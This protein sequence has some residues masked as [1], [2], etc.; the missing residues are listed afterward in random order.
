MKR[1][2][3]A[4]T[5]TPQPNGLT[6]LTRDGTTSHAKTVR[7]R[8]P[9]IVLVVACSQRKR[10]GPPH[11]LRLSSI[12][13]SSARR[14]KQWETRL[15]RVKATCHAAKDLYMGDHWQAACQ[16][17]ELTQR[18][19]S[20]TE[21]WVISAGYGLIS[22]GTAIKPYSAT[23]ASG[24]ADSVWRGAQDGDRD[25]YL[26]EWWHAV[27]RER[28]LVDLLP[29]RGDGAVVVAAG[30]AYL[31]AVSVDLETM[32]AHDS[33]E[34]VSVVSAGARGSAGLLPVTGHFR[35]TVGGT[36]S[37]LNARL[38]ARLAADATT[39]RFRR[40][41]MADFLTRID[42]APSPRV[43]GRTAT[44]AQVID[45][46]TVARDHQTSISRTQALREL[47]RSGIACEQSRFASLWESSATK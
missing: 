32:L 44:D 4:T 7:R 30:A 41:A 17:Y 23:F 15:Q 3:T 11:E 20:R 45:A 40:L 26:N 37:S 39:H 34:R 1:A 12:A 14:S 29:T 38:L 43:R 21:L 36:D 46:I 22:A 27:A 10:I 35:A 31:T 5:R 42:I 19:S 13:A 24:S 8:P 28:S 16:A 18:Y 2:S 9:R 47:R 33:S 25:T 6:S